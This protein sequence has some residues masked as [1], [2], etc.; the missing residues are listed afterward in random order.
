MTLCLR[1]EYAPL[2][3]C[4]LNVKLL[5]T[6]LTST[7]VHFIGE[8]KLNLIFI[9]FIMNVIRNSYSPKSV[10]RFGMVLQIVGGNLAGLVQSFVLHL[11][12]RASAA[13]GCAVAFGAGSVIS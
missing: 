13:I 8:M 9:V 5:K 12:F 4:T 3:R 7:P 2:M 11:I 10:L 1:N 6:V